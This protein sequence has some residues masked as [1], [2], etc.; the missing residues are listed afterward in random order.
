MAEKVKVLAVIPVKNFDER[1]FKCLKALSEQTYPV[2]NIYICSEVKYGDEETKKIINNNPEIH[3]RIPMKTPEGVYW[4]NIVHAYNEARKFFLK[5]K[6]FDCM[7]TVES[8]VIAPPDSLEKLVTAI[9]SFDIVGGIYRLRKAGNICAW[10]EYRNEIAMGQDEFP[11]NMFSLVF[12]KE[13]FDALNRMEVIPCDMTGFGFTLIKKRVLKIIEW[14]YNERWAHDWKFAYD[15]RRY[16]FKAAAHG[17]V[18]C[19]HIDD[20]GKIYRVGDIMDEP[21][22]NPV[23]MSTTFKEEWGDV[24]KK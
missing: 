17:G 9:T 13:D 8:D 18:R 3:A 21:W 12:S 23:N 1:F 19:D 4:M 22:V 2:E 11:S 24:F 10:K 20:D 7:L 6:K 15:L 14:G 5:M 16:R